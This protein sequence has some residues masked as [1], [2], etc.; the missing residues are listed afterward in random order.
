MQFYY[1]I[2]TL[3]NTTQDKK[4]ILFRFINDYLF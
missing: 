4:T 2:S 3:Y 1:T